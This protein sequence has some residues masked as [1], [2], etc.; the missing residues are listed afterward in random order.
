MT[1]EKLIK[2]RTYEEKDA[3]GIVHLF[4]ET[5]HTIN[6]SDYSQEQVETWAPEIPDA[7]AWHE[8]MASRK[9][10]VAVQNDEVVGFAELEEDGRLDMFYL[11][12][13]AVGCGVGKRLYRVV[14]VEARA[15][16]IGR[17]FTEASIT[18]RPFFERQGFRMVREQTV[19]RH[20][21]SL[22]NFVMEKMLDS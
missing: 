6:R 19:Q 21:V 16:G 13:D 11:R 17:I 2:I 15:S 9:T 18:A 8:R 22:T 14:E 4:Y 10:L 20:E 12:R 3:P 7:G 1:T 5:V